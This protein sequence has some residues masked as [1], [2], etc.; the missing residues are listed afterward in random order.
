MLTFIYLF[1]EYVARNFIPYYHSK[2][3][4]EKRLIVSCLI[5]RKENDADV[6]R[7]ETSQMLGPESENVRRHI[8][9][10]KW[11]GVS[12][13]IV[14]TLTIPVM[15]GVLTFNLRGHGNYMEL[16]NSTV[17]SYSVTI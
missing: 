11:I 13:I 5:G 14:I 10:I 17:C 6:M 7:D 8:T 4:L 3:K 16:N 1:H 15:T 2:S 9:A 12:F